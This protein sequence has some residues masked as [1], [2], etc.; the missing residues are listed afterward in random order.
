MNLLITYLLIFAVGALIGFYWYNR[1]SAAV[2]M[3]DE[4]IKSLQDLVEKE[5]RKVTD[6]EHRR[7]VLERLMKSMDK[8]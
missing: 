7:A 6:L 1:H 5:T 8:P 4:H 3:K 2:K